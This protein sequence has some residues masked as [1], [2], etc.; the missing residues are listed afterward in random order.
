[1]KPRLCLCRK[2]HKLLPLS[3]YKIAVKRR[4]YALVTE[5]HDS[6]KKCEGKV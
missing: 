2:C 4:K 6:C 5:R 3:A 1:M